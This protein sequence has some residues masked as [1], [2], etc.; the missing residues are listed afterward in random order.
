MGGWGVVGGLSV[1]GPTQHTRATPNT[2]L[3]T[4]QNNNKTNQNSFKLDAAVLRVPIIPGVDPRTAYGDVAAR[5]VKGI[6][7]EAFGVGNMPDTANLGWLPWLRDQVRLGC[8][9]PWV[10]ACVRV[11]AQGRLAARGCAHANT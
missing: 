8:L 6:L 3:T 5:G 9:L 2:P 10:W 7:L 1:S 11:C 4:S